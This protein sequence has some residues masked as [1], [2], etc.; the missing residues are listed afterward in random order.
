[1][2]GILVEQHREMLNGLFERKLKVL[3]HFLS[4]NKGWRADNSNRTQN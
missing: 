3:V 1:M 4:D 2:A